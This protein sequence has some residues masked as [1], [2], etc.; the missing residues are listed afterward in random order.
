MLF[1]YVNGDGEPQAD[2]LRRRQRLHPRRHRR[3]FHRQAFP[4]L[5]RQRHRLRPTA[6]KDEDERISLKTVLEPVAEALGN[7]PAMSRKSYVH[8][9]L[10]DALQEDPRDPLRGMKRPRAAPPPVER[11][12][13]P[14]SHFLARTKR[15]RAGQRSRC[16]L[17]LRCLARHSPP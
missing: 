4:H 13:R 3:R 17:N 1:Q 16:G 9:A 14:S 5:G 8:P 7:T 6:E 15:A 2:H 11:R 12:N 10:I